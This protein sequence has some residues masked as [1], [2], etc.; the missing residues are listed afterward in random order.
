MIGMVESSQVDSDVQLELTITLT[1]VFQNFMTIM[2][3]IPG[4]NC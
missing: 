1:Y 4:F 2:M 3:R